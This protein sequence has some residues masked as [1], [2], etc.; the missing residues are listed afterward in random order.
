MPEP[1]SR[2]KTLLAQVR[3]LAMD[4]DGVLT[5]GRIYWGVTVGGGDLVEMK[6]FDVRDGLGISVARAAGLGIAWITG[7]ASPLV[8]RRARELRVE[9][10]RQRV[11][12]KGEALLDLCRQLEVPPEASAYMGDDLNDVLGFEA[13]GMRIAVAGAAPEL[14]ARAD[15][16][17]EAPGGQG[18]VREVVE[19]I[20]RARG[21]WEAAAA[22]FVAALA[23]PETA[24]EPM[25]DPLAQGQ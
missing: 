7:R 20:L 2:T 17:T 16:V 25:P 6:A 13:A 3:L 12:H 19:A 22:R 24:F 18:A 9:H 8:E 14:L 23:A 1:S 21:E 11:R 5:D 10:L 4:V 15:W